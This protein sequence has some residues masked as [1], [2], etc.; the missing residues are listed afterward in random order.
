MLSKI[1]PFCLFKG[2]PIK[3]VFDIKRVCWTCPSCRN[4]V[5]ASFNDIRWQEL[6]MIKMMIHRAKIKEFGGQRHAG[7][8]LKSDKN[9][10]TIRKTA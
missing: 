1:A 5:S 2:K 8:P 4:S 7:R 6:V 3:M 10:W 9:C